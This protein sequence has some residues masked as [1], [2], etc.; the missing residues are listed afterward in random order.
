MQ[1]LSL[2]A[3]LGIAAL[4]GFVYVIVKKHWK[5]VVP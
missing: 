1:E 5:K 2:G 4:I 3:T